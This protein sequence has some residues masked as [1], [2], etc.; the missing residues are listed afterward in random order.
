M[1]ENLS[2]HKAPPVAKWLAHKKSARW[3]LHFT[4]TS[5][6]W[7]NLVEGWFALLT[8][9]RL[10]RGTFNSVA[11]LEEA[12]ELWA[13]HWNDDPKPF[14]WRKTAEEIVA[15]VR[16]GRVALTSVKNATDHWPRS[17][18]RP[19]RWGSRGRGP[20]L[21]GIEPAARQAAQNW[22]SEPATQSLADRSSAD[23]T[24]GAARFV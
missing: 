15:K 10:R 7:L 11:Q 3:H 13:E 24:I 14:V 20:R 23:A 5:S 8:E 4:P 19:T 22:S 2:A 18:P 6:S 1:L 16:R 12:I 21:G 17:P 9:R